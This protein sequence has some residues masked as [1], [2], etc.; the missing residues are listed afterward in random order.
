SS[1]N[2][3]G[4]FF[5]SRHRYLF[6]RENS[7][8]SNSAASITSIANTLYKKCC[9]SLVNLGQPNKAAEPVAKKLTD[10]F[11]SLPMPLRRTITFDNGIQAVFELEL[12]TN[13]DA[14]GSLS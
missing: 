3:Y 10:V 4:F 6:T 5:T 1:S 14:A 7:G 8:P 13:L 9:T 2:G 12:K 11:T